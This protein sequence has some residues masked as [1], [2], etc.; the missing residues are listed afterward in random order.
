MD[1]I[2]L[3]LVGLL[4]LNSRLSYRYMADVVGLSVNAVHTRV[5]SLKDLE[6][7]RNLSANLGD[8]ILKPIDVII[9]GQI[10]GIPTQKIYD[11]IFG[12]M[13]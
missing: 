8:V 13:I 10:N 9:F 2:D 1:S 5:K 6:I 4:R 12:S 11:T 3:Q 7:V